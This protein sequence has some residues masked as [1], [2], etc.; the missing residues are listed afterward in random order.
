MKE[1]IVKL[2]LTYLTAERLKAWADTARLVVVPW[3]RDLKTQVVAMLRAKAA[4]TQ[5]TVD[6]TVINA[7]DTFLE[8]ILPD[9][10]THL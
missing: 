4:T 8:A 7:L 2:L 1:W 10:P 3:L 6:D 5:T 9:N